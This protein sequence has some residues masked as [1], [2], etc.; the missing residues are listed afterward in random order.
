MMSPSRDAVLI[1]RLGSIGDTVV[2]LPCFHAIA[3]AFPGHRRVLLTN[4]LASVRA[5]SAESV[6]D[7]TGL[8][9]EVIYF[10]TGE[11]RFREAWAMMAEV[12]RVRAS[13]LIYLAER[14]SA[15]AVFRDVAFFKAAGVPKIAG[16]PWSRQ[17]RECRVD[18]ASSELEFE[19]E[20]LARMLGRVIPVGLAPA[21]W[22][23][24]LSAS[25]IEKAG[26]LLSVMAA[27]GRPLAIAP[28]AK[29]PQKDWGK[30][31]WAALLDALAEDCGAAGLVIVGAADE[32]T[33][34][35]ELAQ[36]WNS[37]VL[38]LCGTLT[39]RE[40]AAALGRCRLLMC[41]DSGPMHLAASQGTPCVA[42]FGNYNRPRQWYPFGPGHRVIHDARGV[43][44]IGMERVLQEVRA[45]LARDA[46]TGEARMPAAARA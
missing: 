45:L 44:A 35:D 26:A 18:A 19:A 13:T 9:D 21:D 29:I 24:C 40:T 39:P 6:L 28:G 32:R 42:L 37:P 10:P 4:A 31:R 36:R 7:G 27:R 2:A 16:G 12:Q 5:S 8:I 11:F 14:R 17:L 46:A 15:A 22:D 38:N 43:R 30:D 25:E 34:G 3:R 1:F 20:R 41:H 23:L 33:L